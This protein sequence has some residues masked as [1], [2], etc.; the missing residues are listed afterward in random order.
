MIV[1]G[2]HFGFAVACNGHEDKA[3]HILSPRVSTREEAI[4]LLRGMAAPEAPEC[5]ALEGE[6]LMGE[7]RRLR[8]GTGVS[9]GAEAEIFARATSALQMEAAEAQVGIYAPDAQEGASW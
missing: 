2:V 6:F 1:I 8:H 4:S 5:A 9:A 3:Y 7:Y